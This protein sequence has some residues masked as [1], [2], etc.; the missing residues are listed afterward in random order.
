MTA[1]HRTLSVPRTAHLHQLGTLS[2]ATQHV[3]VVCHG[4][5]QLAKYFI[6]HFQGLE[7]EQT[8]ILAPE[9][10][11][12]F[13]LEGFSGRVGATWMTKEERLLEIEDYVRYLDLVWEMVK[14]EAPNAKLTVLGFSQG[15][16]TVC[17]WLAFSAVPCEKLILWAGA[18]PEDIEYNV[19]STT[20]AHASVYMV[21]GLQDP[22]ITQERLQTQLDILKSQNIQPVMVP[23][24]GKHELNKE[25][26]AQ[27]K[28]DLL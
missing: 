24:E 20:L 12:K 26:L 17:R 5:G 28:G 9:G 10:L 19:L 23:F 14:S 18:F 21:Y 11:S 15:A 4:Y 3:W 25:I 16:V 2:P 27:L 7:D 6:R 8:V 22:F 13:Y 1:Q